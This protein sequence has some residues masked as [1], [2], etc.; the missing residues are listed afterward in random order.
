MGLVVRKLLILF[1]KYGLAIGLLV[2]VVY[3]QWEPPGGNGLSHLWHNR[4]L[5]GE[6]DWLALVAAWCCQVTAT[7]ITIIRWGMLIRALDLPLSGW[8][9]W[10]LGWV[11]ILFNTLLPGSVG[12]DLVKATLAARSY[13]DKRTFAVASV[14]FDRI[15]ALW[16]LFAMVA[17][18]GFFRLWGGGMAEASPS[19]VVVVHSVAISAL[20]MLV[21]WALLG[22]VPS[23]WAEELAKTMARKAQV[24]GVLGE[25]AR[26]IVWYRHRP[27]AV[28]KAMFIT[29]CGQVLFVL[30]FFLVAK[31]LGDNPMKETLP[32]LGWH[33]L[34]VPLGMVLMAVP[35]FPGGLGIGEWGYGALYTQVVGETGRA[36]GMVAS[37]GHR[38]LGWLV[39]LLGLR[40]WGATRLSGQNVVSASGTNSAVG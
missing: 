18:A 15:L 16:G 36:T 13:P 40:A 20:V 8:E 25:L 27:L 30:S 17:V 4:I 29:S 14:I 5:T 9:T 24:L 3:R 10:R 22:L 2:A 38:V 23:L 37:L 11:G 28:A 12:G 1:L 26:A 39:A 34:L 19:L 7:G 32:G 33:F 31:A 6:I 21:V 35:L